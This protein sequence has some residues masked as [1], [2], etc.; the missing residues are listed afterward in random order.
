MQNETEILAELYRLN[1]QNQKALNDKA[2][3]K[4][5]ILKSLNEPFNAGLFFE[6][7]KALVLADKRQ[8]ETQE[9]IEYL[10]QKKAENEPSYL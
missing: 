2:K 4:N 9:Q 10:N 7:S 8:K 3:F 1:K 6:L 5:L